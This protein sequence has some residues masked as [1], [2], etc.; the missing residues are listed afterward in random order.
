MNFAHRFILGLLF[1]L[2]FATIYGC[3][4]S[5]AGVVPTGSPQAGRRISTAATVGTLVAA[6]PEHVQDFTFWNQSGIATAV[7][8]SWAA[9]WATW[10]ETGQPVHAAEFHAAGGKH[11]VAYTDPNY[12]YVEPGNA[13]PGTYPES[14]F[15]HGAN[16]VRSQLAIYGGTE[17]YLLPNSSA[18]Q[19]GFVGIAGAFAATGAYDYIYADGISS[20]LTESDSRLSPVPVEITTDAQYVEGMKQLLAR[21]PLPTIANGYE[22]GNPLVEE[23][24]VGASNVAGL[25]GETCF[26]E[27]T[28]AVTGSLWSEE[29]DALLY[30]TGHRLFAFCG[31]RGQEGDT[32]PYRTYYLASWWLTYDK[33]YSVSLEEFQSNAGIYVFPEQM[34]VP[35]NPDETVTNV[36]ALKWWTGA[37]MRRFDACYYDRVLWGGCAAVVNPSASASAL[38]P[39]IG[40]T[41]HHS[42]ALDE[43]NLFE[44]GRASLSSVV[45]TALAPGTA[46]ILF[47]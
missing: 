10:V 29:A 6:I 30:T 4:G 33:N 38:M 27:V 21:S 3:G 43:N 15:G 7:P 18:S 46:V 11:T 16:G 17:Y 45:P 25:Y 36:S 20:S 40:L 44:G 39:P 9:R 42:L 34:I 2:A 31:G 41:Y 32:R 37:Y 28:H 5:T 47:Q 35:T 23:E 26:T 14:A 24:Y 12:F 22:N 19:T 8:A 1:A 13:S